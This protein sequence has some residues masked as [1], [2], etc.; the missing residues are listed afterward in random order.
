MVRRR[1]RR[2]SRAT[3][4]AAARL[5]R[6]RALPLHDRR[7]SASGCCCCRAC[8]ASAAGQRRLPA[9]SSSARSRFQPAEFA[10]IAIIIFLRQLP[11]R[12]APAAGHRRAPRSSGMTIPPLKHFG[13]LLV[14]WGAAMVMLFVIQ[15]LGSSLMFFGGFLAMLYVATE[16]ALVRRSSG[17]RCSP[18]ARGSCYA[19]P[20]TIAEPRRRLARPVRPDAVRPGRR[21]L[22]DR[23][24]AVRAGRRRASSGRAS[25]QALLTVRR[26][27]RCCPRR[28]P[29][30]S[31]R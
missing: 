21:Q 23:A 12:H 18:P 25:A 29:T 4:V 9:A 11:A 1:P 6:A 28:T 30:S 2:S 16:P 24:V 14:V 19:G 17:W 7:R 20:A 10:K 5:P 22:P 26:R 13:P 31:T 8:P 27:R 15:D 3:I